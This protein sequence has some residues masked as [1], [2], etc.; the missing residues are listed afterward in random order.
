VEINFK[1]KVHFGIT[2]SL[3][4]ALVAVIPGHGQAGLKQLKSPQVSV[5]TCVVAP[6]NRSVSDQLVD[7]FLTSDRR[8]D[9]SFR[10]TR[11][12]Q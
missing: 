10:R 6:K 1:Q 9:F 3:I 5:A 2:A 12:E 11:S 7:Q 4:G 8:G